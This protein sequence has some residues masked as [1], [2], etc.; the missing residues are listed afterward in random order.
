MPWSALREVLKPL[1]KWLWRRRSIMIAPNEG[2]WSI[3]RLQVDLRAQSGSWPRAQSGRQ[4]RAQSGSQPRAHDV[5]VSF[6]DQ[7]GPQSQSCHPDMLWGKMRGPKVPRHHSCQSCNQESEP[8]FCRVTHRQLHNEWRKS[9]DPLNWAI[10]PWNLE[11]V[12]LEHGGGS[13]MWHPQMVDWTGG[14]SSG[15]G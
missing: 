2:P 9:G 10:L 14:N 8:P 11:Q 13:K 7:T 1:W 12:G 3:V 15:E 6:K 5:M 4:P